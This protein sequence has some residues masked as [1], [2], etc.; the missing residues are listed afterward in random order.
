MPYF[1][2][3]K[4]LFLLAPLFFLLACQNETPAVPAARPP[5]IKDTNLIK[6]QAV[7]P[8]E[9]V[10][11]SPMDMAYFPIDYPVL[12]MNG[13]TTA[14][15]LARLIYS[16]PHR[17]G[18]KLFGNI[19]KWGEP[20]RLGANEATEIQFFRPVTIQGRRMEKGQYILYAIPQ[21]D[22]WTIVFNS[23]LHTWGLK[24]DLSKDVA[25]FDIPALKKDQVVEHFTMVFQ[26]AT[27]GADLVLAWEDREAR[28][29]L[30][31]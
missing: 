19:V 4:N 27:A 14:P 5:L 9:P 2:A 24:F 20:W 13:E 23:N 30:K 7:N 1:F 25:K 26:Q 18:R 11:L 15:P 22:K 12:K 16:R 21:E 6:R 28:L 10:D 8:Y 17:Q 31:F 3:M 29:P